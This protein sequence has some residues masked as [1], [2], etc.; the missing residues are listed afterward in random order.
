MTCHTELLA[1]LP[2]LHALVIFSVRSFHVLA[3]SITQDLGTFR[4]L[5]FDSESH[6]PTSAGYRRYPLARTVWDAADDVGA[7]LDYVSTNITRYG[8]DARKVVLVAHS[9]GAHISALHLL[10]RMKA[11]TEA[12]DGQQG[13]GLHSFIGLSGVYDINAH[14]EHEKKRGVHEISALKPA[15]GFSPA[16]FAAASPTALAREL[17]EK[18]AKQWDGETPGKKP[19][20][21]P[22]IRLVHCKDD[23]TVPFSS[24]TDLWEALARVADGAGAEPGAVRVE[25]LEEGGHASLLREVMLAKTGGLGA[26]EEGDI[27]PQEEPFLLQ[28]VRDVITES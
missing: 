4:T 2:A 13:L 5:S 23:S 1:R 14:Y 10:S 26:G 8:G 17:A 21:P 24:S 16:E 3:F 28:M 6:V 9:S 27:A 12:G 19:A 18:C 25:L 20:P 15:N 11:V 22:Q 7:A